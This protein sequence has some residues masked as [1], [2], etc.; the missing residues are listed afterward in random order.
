MKRTAIFVAMA[1]VAPLVQGCSSSGV[2]D[3]LGMGKNSP[4]E[5]QVRTT[6]NLSMPPDLQL[7]A[8]T[9]PVAEQDGQLANVPQANS[10][11]SNPP[12]EN[13]V[14]A[15]PATGTAAPAPQPQVAAAQPTNS[16]DDVYARYGISKTKPDGTPKTSADLIAELRKAQL[17]EKRR[18]NPNYGTIW[19]IGNLFKD[20]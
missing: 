12:A 16:A 10:V 2:V 5:T 15:A 1:A 17:E 6:Q 11:A 13:A 20:G 3:M 8:P 4:D 18:A 19:N 7:H 9:G 14:P